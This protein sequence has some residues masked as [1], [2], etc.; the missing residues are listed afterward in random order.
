MLTVTRRALLR[1]TAIVP[2]AVALDGCAQLQSAFQAVPG[3]AKD[4]DL[5]AQAVALILPSIRTLTGLAG[6][7]WNEANKLVATIENTAGQIS[8]ASGAALPSMVQTIGTALAGLAGTLLGVPGLPTI[9]STVL[10]AAGALLPALEQAVGIAQAPI[11][12]RRFAAALTPDQARVQLQ[13]IVAG[14]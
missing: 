7:A 6:G 13:A 2:V 10:G 3:L 1:S 14:R 12:Q 9:V 11:T 4:A 8:G 5:I